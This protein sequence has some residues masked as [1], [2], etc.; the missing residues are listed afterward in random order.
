MVTVVIPARYGSSR[1]PGKALA[2]LRGKPLIQHV[3]ERA[4]VAPRVDQVIIATDD[5]RIADMV[6]RFGAEVV[7]SNDPF[8]TGTDRVAGVARQRPGEVFINLQGDEIPLHPELVTDLV[9]PFVASGALMGTLKRRLSSAEALQNPGVVK[10]VTDRAGKA[11][12]FSRA[13]V[14]VIRDEGPGAMRAG[15]HF[16]H[17]G[18]YA[19]T[20]ETLLRLADLPTTPL[21]AAESLEQLRALE[22]G[23]PVTVWETQH[24]SL[25]VDT[26]EDL[27][28]AERALG[29]R[30]DDNLAQVSV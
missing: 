24:P 11:L 13:P 19:Y 28:A 18:I 25:R 7:L 3:Y 9:G 4:R 26:P 6:K 22:H 15:L 5:P 10:V 16:M 14:P 20:R 1:F 30:L 21:E 27:A 29:P 2:L 12:Y 8:R 17:L 23:I